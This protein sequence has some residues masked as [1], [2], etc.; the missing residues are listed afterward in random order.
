[1]YEPGS[2]FK[3]VPF[4]AALADHV[5]T[6]TTAFSRPRH[7]ADRRLPVPRC[8]DSTALERLTATQILEYSSNIGTY[9][10]TSELGESRLLAQVQRLGFGRVSG[11]NFP[12]EASGI[13]MDAA[14]WSPTDI[15]SL[16]IGQQDAVTPLQVLDAYNT[17]ANGGVFVTPSLV[18]A[19]VDADGILDPARRPGQRRALPVA[20]AAGARQDARPGRRG[21]H[22]DRGRRR[23][24]TRS[25]ARPALLRSR[26][27]ARRSTS[28]VPTTLRS[29]GSPRPSTRS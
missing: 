9:E 19:K 15:A 13:L 12:G 3:I 21:R 5:I 18:R 29:S 8:R 17:I 16:P 11:L 28:L 22:R 6:P 10:I 24:A 2:V 14:G 4:S 23:R 26:L 7:G 20:V 25:P 27:L 1:M